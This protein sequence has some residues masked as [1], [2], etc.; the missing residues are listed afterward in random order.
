MIDIT[1]MSY[2]KVEYSSERE[3]IHLATTFGDVPLICLMKIPKYAFEVIEDDV[4]E[5]LEH[6]T[7]H[8]VLARINPSLSSKFD[9]IFPNIDSLEEV[10][11]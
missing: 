2:P 4:E 8:I 11:K 7:L 10:R 9:N 6:E 1:I 3:H 5:I